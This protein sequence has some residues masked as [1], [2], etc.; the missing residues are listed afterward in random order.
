MPKLADFLQVSLSNMSASLS[1][2]SIT[3]T[4]SIQNGWPDC[5]QNETKRTTI[6]GTLAFTSNIGFIF[7]AVVNMGR[8]SGSSS[9]LR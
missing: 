4:L 8:A 3:H 1:R 2:R 9:L 7:T 5:H 6:G